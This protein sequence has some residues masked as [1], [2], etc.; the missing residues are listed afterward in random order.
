MDVVFTTPIASFE[1]NV[2]LINAS[3]R[4]TQIY[5]FILCS[6]T[7]MVQNAAYTE[8]LVFAMKSISLFKQVKSNI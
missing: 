3:E 2:Q 1:N 8:G 6:N 4:Q 7:P 5:L